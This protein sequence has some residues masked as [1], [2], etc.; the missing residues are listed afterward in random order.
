MQI[1]RLGEFKGAP[2]FVMELV[3]GRSLK[4]LLRHAAAVPS[5]PGSS[6][7]RQ[8]AAGLQAIH[9]AGILHRDLSTNNILV[10]ASDMA[11]ILDFGLSRDVNIA[12]SL[13]R[14]SHLAGTLPYVA[15][16]QIEGR[17]SNPVAEVFSLR[18]HLV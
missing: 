8:V 9:D 16:E 14:Q 10:T 5:A 1:Y 13:I 18:R 12:H 6:I 3:A 17:G 2:Y 11:K 7:M 15:P 4:D